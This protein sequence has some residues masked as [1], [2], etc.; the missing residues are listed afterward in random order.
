MPEQAH[1]TSVEAL[2][3]FRSSLLVYLAKTRPILEEACDDVVRMRGWLQSDRRSHWENQ[4]RQRRKE[5]EAAQQALFSAGLSS[6]GDLKTTEQRAVQKAR[7]ALAATEEKV[8]LLK[9]WDK[10]FDNRVAPAVK[11]LEHLRSVLANDLPKGVSYLGQVIRTLD[12]Y[13][14]LSP[15]T[16]SVTSPTS[17]TSST[18]ADQPPPEPT[19]DEP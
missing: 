2:E 19:K 8:R 7:G 10:D 13:A 3:S 11:Q 1:V 14:G 6:L 4:I 5:L 18:A 17:S 15:I 9:R 12:S 16:P